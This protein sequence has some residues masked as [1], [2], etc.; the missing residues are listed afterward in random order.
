MFAV[1]ELLASVPLKAIFGKLTNL[2]A[3]AIWSEIALQLN[4]SEDFRSIKENLSFIQAFL[5]DAERQSSRL[6][7]VRHAQEAQGCSL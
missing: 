4:C 6:E 1:G 5:N 3:D 2:T 7:S